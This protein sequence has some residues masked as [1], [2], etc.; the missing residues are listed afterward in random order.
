MIANNPEVDFV[1]YPRS[2]KFFLKPERKIVSESPLSYY[3]GEE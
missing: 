3:D 1:S 2:G